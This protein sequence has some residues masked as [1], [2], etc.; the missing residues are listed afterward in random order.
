MI[1]DL[2]GNHAYLNRAAL[3]GC[4][5]ERL[6]QSYAKQHYTRKYL[7]NTSVTGRLGDIQILIRTLESG[8]NALSFGKTNFPCLLSVAIISCCASGL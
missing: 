4:N 8:V 5:N 6:S 3:V 7:R 1:L 2:V